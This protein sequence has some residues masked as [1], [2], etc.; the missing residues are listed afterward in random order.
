MC[1]PSSYTDLRLTKSSL[2]LGNED[3]YNV[4]FVEGKLHILRKNFD[5]R[6][7]IQHSGPYYGY[8]LPSPPPGY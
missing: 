3:T 2:S 4:S 7:E 1:T 8:A 5:L 6:A